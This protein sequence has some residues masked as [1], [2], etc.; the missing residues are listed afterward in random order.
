MYAGDII[1]VQTMATRQVRIRDDHYQFIQDE[2]LSLSGLVQTALDEVIAGDRALPSEAKRPTEGHE[3]TRT[4][5]SLSGEHD[6]FI[7]SHDFVFAVFVHQLIEERIERE[8]KLQQLLG[9]K[10]P[11]KSNSNGG[12]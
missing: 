8:R 3:L 10:H 7:A 9:G 11:R 12:V 1:Y 5:V 4:S 6:E 2:S